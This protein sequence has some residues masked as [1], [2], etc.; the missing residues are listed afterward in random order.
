MSKSKGN[1]IGIDEVTK[2]AY[3]LNDEYEF[4][5][6][7]GQLVDW[8]KMKVWKAPEGYRT[9]LSTGKQPVFLHIKGEPVPLLL[10]GYTQHRESQ[11]YWAGLLEK[12]EHVEPVSKLE[13][14]SE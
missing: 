14:A 2:G 1:A 3:T 5:D 11:N 13:N 8:E 6:L 12:Y 10:N 9:S 4:R 7:H